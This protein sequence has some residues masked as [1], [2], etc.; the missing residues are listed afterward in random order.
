[1][2]RRSLAAVDWPLRS[3]RLS[4]R[5]AEP[6]DAARTWPY[7]RRP[8]VSRWIS[9]APVDVEQHRAWFTDPTR[10]ARSLVVEHGDEVIGD[11]M[12]KLVDPYAQAE[13]VEQA[14]TSD[15]VASSRTASRTTRH[16]SV[17][18]SASAS[19]VNPTP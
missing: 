4:L 9:V 11:L 17:C 5:P 3:A 12:V 14:A 2:T 8:D 15:Y 6:A 19:A 10:L 7:W 16:P 13:V 1:M 18:W